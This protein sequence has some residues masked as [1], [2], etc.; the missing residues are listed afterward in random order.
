VEHVQLRHYDPSQPCTSSRSASPSHHRP[1]G[2]DHCCVKCGSRFAS[3]VMLSRHEGRCCQGWQSREGSA[4]Q[5]CHLCSEKIPRSCIARHLQQQH[6]EGRL[7]HV[8][9]YPTLTVQENACV[10]CGHHFRYVGTGTWI[11]LV[12]YL[13]GLSHQFEMG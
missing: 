5:T 8:A 6:P 9:A 2:A 3:S 12:Q 1:D 10:S 7:Q 13:K 11:V 4:E